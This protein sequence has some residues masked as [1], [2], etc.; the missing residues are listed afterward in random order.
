MEGHW[1]RSAHSHSYTRQSVKHKWG[2]LSSG[3][4]SDVHAPSMFQACKQTRAKNDWIWE[5]VKYKWESSCHQ[6]KL[7]KRRKSNA[8]SV[9][10]KQCEKYDH[11]HHITHHAQ[12][13]AKLENSCTMCICERRKFLMTVMFRF[14]VVF[15]HAGCQMSDEIYHLSCCSGLQLYMVQGLDFVL[16]HPRDINMIQR[17]VQSVSNVITVLHHWVS[18]RILWVDHWTKQSSLADTLT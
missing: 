4:T 5:L 12:L 18:R 16:A 2:P 14:V 15:F 11:I 6:A 7:K 17:L 8:V 3:P 13:I 9:F 1:D 10:D